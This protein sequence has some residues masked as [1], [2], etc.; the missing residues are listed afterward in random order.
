[1][2][3]LDEPRPALP[4]ESPW[5]ELRNKSAV[6]AILLLDAATVAVLVLSEGA[7]QW[8]GTF[9][10]VGESIHRFGP[11][12]AA[13][14]LVNL[15][16]VMG[17]FVAH[18]FLKIWQSLHK[19]HG[20]PKPNLV[21]ALTAVAALYFAGAVYLPHENPGPERRS[22]LPGG[23]DRTVDSPSEPPPSTPPVP[24]PRLRL[25]FRLP[26][27]IRGSVDP[28]KLVVDSNVTDI[29]L[30]IPV[31]YASFKTYTLILDGQNFQGFKIM[32]NGELGLLVDRQDLPRG[33]HTLSVLEQQKG[34]TKEDTLDF[35]FEV[36]D[37]GL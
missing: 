16:I 34:K 24:R 15:V 2:N 32:N 29:E 10:F 37:S 22:E 27:F 6:T 17:G 35:K 18:L 5:E 14:A 7:L 20:G 9:P 21:A 4:T 19:I 31:A 13:T 25:S 23:I 33:Q 36:V 1:M 26:R 28:P 11:F 12:I 3:K 8:L 30:T